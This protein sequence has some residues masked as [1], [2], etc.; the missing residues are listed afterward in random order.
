L[1]R[2]R[3]KT[4]NDFNHLTPLADMAAWLRPY[5]RLIRPEIAL[6]DIAL[7]LSAAVLA[8][9]VAYPDSIH[10][11]GMFPEPIALIAVVAGGYCAITSSYVFNDYMDIDIDAIN[12]PGR[13]LPS[14]DVTP[15]SAFL[16]AIL[17]VMAAVVVAIIL[18][19]QSLAVLLLAVV[20]ISV[21][22]TVVKRRIWASFVPVGVAYGLVPLGIWLAFDPAV[23][24]DILPLP[25]LLFAMMICVTD[26]GFTLSGVSRDVEG[27][28]ELGVP[29]FPV[30]FGIPATALLITVFWTAGIGLSIGIW[31][32]AGLGWFFLTAAI[33]GGGWMLYQCVDF[34]RNPGAARGGK[35]FLQASRYRGVL[36]AAL[37]T[38]VIITVVI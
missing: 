8:C 34:T 25:A 24:G 31:M 38:D 11:T 2:V 28:R 37:V 21:Y 26:W 12:L 22:S 35:L 33:G 10:S 13:P 6:M 29:T 18:N 32:A 23:P 9:F 36:F 5:L 3:S 7:P 30:I 1:F 27:D 4:V 16:F 17:L 15:K 14:G 20:T 19:P